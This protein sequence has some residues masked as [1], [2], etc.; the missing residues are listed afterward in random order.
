MIVVVRLLLFFLLCVIMVGIFVFKIFFLYLV[1]LIKLIGI[2]IIVFVCN[3]LFFV[4][5]I[6]LYIVVGV[7]LRIN[8]FGLFFKEVSLILVIE[9]VILCCLVIFIVFGLFI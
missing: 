9:C 1:V 7:F 5:L 2:V 3:F 4:I 6:I 8:S